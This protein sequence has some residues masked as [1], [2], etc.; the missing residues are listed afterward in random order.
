[1]VKEKQWILKAKRFRKISPVQ[2]K[3]MH[4]QGKTMLVQGKNNACSRK[5]NGY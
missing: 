4:I 5:K 3:A 1:M 2:G